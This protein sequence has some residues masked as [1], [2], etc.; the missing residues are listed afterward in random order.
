MIKG[1]VALTFDDGPWI[2]TSQ[3]L[4]VLASYNLKATFFIVGNSMGR[5]RI[6]DPTTPWPAIMRRMYSAGHQIASHSWTHHDLSHVNNIIEE[7]QIVYNEMAFR[8]LFGW[9]PTYFRCPYLACTAGSDSLDI[10]DNL[11]YHII[12]TNLDTK[13]YI[14]NDANLIQTSKDRY[15]SAL[16]NN[17]AANSYIPLAHDIHYQTVVNLTAFMIDTLLARGY[18]PTTVG[19]CLGDPPENWYRDASSV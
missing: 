8:N 5:G 9:F 13:D 2:Y 4:D 7:T 6:D 12:D 18:T 1:T 17:P 3:M 14:Y 10:L 19:E 15:S 11:G 16:S